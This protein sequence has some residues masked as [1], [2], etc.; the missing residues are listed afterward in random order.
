[1][2]ILLWILILWF[3]FRALGRILGPVIKVAL[4]RFVVRTVEGQMRQQAEAFE[5]NANRSPYGETH[6]QGN[7]R[8]TE[9][10][11]RPKTSKHLPTL[12]DVAEDVEFVETK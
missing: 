10:K 4:A 5:R 7:T 3:G 9:D 6:Q 11:T 2:K 12:N 8:V 1:M